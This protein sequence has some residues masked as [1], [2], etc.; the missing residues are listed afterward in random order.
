MY[1]YITKRR[2]M[3]PLACDAQDMCLCTVQYARFY[4][5]CV[6]AHSLSKRVSIFACVRR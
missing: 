4:Y 6:H 1:T 5:L 2:K 3:P